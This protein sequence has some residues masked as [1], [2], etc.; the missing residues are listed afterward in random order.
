MKV[1]SIA[2]ITIFLLVLCTLPHEMPGLTALETTSGALTTNTGVVP[3]T[4]GAGRKLTTLL[5]HTTM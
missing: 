4:L 3:T 2:P 1:G 5:C